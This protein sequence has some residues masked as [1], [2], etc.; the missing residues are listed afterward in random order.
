MNKNE[1]LREDR[2]LIVKAMLD[3]YPE[4][5]ERVKRYLMKDATTP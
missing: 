3:E 5:K 1:K 2:W 4:L